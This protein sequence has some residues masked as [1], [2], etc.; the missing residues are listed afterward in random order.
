MRVP[1]RLIS[2]MPRET[3]TPSARVA[4]Y[5]RFSPKPEG[6]AGENY[7][8][9][10]QVHACRAKVLADTGC[11]TPALYVDKNASGA[12]LDRDDLDRLRDDIQ[13]K[14]IDAI[15]VYCLDRLSREPAD[16]YILLNEAEKH[17]AKFVFVDEKYDDTA[18]GEVNMGVKMIFAKYEK[19]KFAERARR[20][21][22]TK[23]R[24]GNPHSCSPPM[25]YQ[26]KG[27]KFG[28]KGEYEIVPSQVPTVLRIFA[29]ARQGKGDSEIARILNAEGVPTARAGAKFTVDGKAVETSG[30]WHRNTIRQVLEKTAYYGERMEAGAVIAVPFIMTKEYW[31]E[32]HAAQAATSKGRAG[33][34]SK[35]YLLSGKLWCV[36]GCR[37]TAVSG[38]QGSGGYRCREAQA[39]PKRKCE[40]PGIN[41]PK[42]EEIIWTAIWE[43]LTQPALL[44]S[45]IATYRDSLNAQPKGKKDDQVRRLEKARKAVARAEAILYNP[46]INLDTANEKLVQ[47]RHELVAIESEIQVAKVFEMPSRSTI[48]AMSKAFA[49]GGPKLHEF[50][51][52]RGVLERVVRHILFGNGKV[53]IAC[54][55]AIEP[56]LNC[57]RRERANGSLTVEIPFVIQRLVA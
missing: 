41:R 19:R 25:G 42:M 7:S 40:R 35:N 12:N 44:E 33:R 24:N 10:S 39:G 17:G 32:C 53:D 13:K 49:E 5:A 28:C 14:L 31:N 21:R 47:A 3:A 6:K 9:D 46:N 11:A 38:S 43:T 34:P 48:V 55:I 20:G 50:G 29:L 30:L 51:H 45:M 27:H 4:I 57:H 15:Y 56:A 52:R 8:I 16:T 18:E 36:C 22:K 37:C 1:D 23:A 54:K 2:T 26:Y